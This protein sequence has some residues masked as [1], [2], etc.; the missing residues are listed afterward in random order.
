MDLVIT[1]VSAVVLLGVLIFVHELGHFAVAKWAG[2]GVN[3]FSLGFGPKLWGFTRGRTE[4]RV[5]WIPLGGYVRM[6]GENPGQEVA[7]GDI[8]QSFSHKSVGRRLAIVAAGPAANVIFALVVYYL[9]VVLWGMPAPLPPRVGQVGP[10]TPAA[11]AGMQ[12]GDLVLSVD[13]RPIK[14]W[15]TMRDI[16]LES[17]GRPLRF[18][19][20]RQG[21]R[22]TLT[23]TPK[24]HQVT[25]L[26][27]ESVVQ[28]RIGISR[29]AMP[30]PAVVGKLVAGGPAQAAG[31]EVGD[32]I[33]SVDGQPVSNWGDLLRKV[34]AG[35]GKALRLG[36]ER[37][38]ARLQV[39]VTPQTNSYLGPDGKPRKSYSLGILPKREFYSRSVG[40][41]AAVPL[42]FK[43]TYQAGEVIFLTVVK[44]LQRK[45][46]VKSLGGP[47]L[48]AQAAG[49][50]AK[51]GLAS[52]LGL[53]AL[54]SVNLAILNLLPIPAL[55]G[56][57]LFF[58]LIEAVIRRPVPLKVR[59]GAQQVGVALLLFLMAMV[60]YNDIERLFTNGAG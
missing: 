8:P 7:A 59:Q 28:Y 15:Q 32:R 24:G 54:I 31:V 38:G 55:D 53:A 29:E 49:E 37:R 19:V 36:I 25:N 45:V 50:A 27:G 2:V 46:A 42:A 52:L 51:S 9:L 4:Y 5:S 14:D 30:F 6:V 57:H 58:F 56:G 23:I 48:I 26:F 3:T 22:V 20:R 21:R 39:T 33:V 17:R 41:L 16:V 34:A 13:G 47:I 12:P 11:A 40:L 10:H 44:L 1:I 43:R 18:V 35:Q 60:F